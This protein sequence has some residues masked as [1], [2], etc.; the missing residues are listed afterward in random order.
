MS[1]SVVGFKRFDA[2]VSADLPKGITFR[3]LVITG[4]IAGT[5]VVFFLETIDCFFSLGY[6]LGSLS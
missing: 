6:H 5:V 4:V 2:V 1:K 3:V